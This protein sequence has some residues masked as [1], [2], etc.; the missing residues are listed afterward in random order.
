MSD[1]NIYKGLLGHFNN[2]DWV[3][4]LNDTSKVNKV[5]GIDTDKPLP[6]S[7]LLDANPANFRISTPEEISNA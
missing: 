2:G 4:W 7:A 1:S 5:S 3:T 6:F